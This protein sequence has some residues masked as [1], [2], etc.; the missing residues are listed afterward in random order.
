[1]Q[2]FLRTKVLDRELAVDLGHHRSAAH[3]PEE[4]GRRV[5]D[6]QVIEVAAL[7]RKVRRRRGKARPDRALDHR[8]RQGAARLI[9][10]GGGRQKAVHIYSIIA[11][12]LLG[13]CR[14]QFR[15]PTNQDLE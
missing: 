7:D 14:V 10:R 6:H 5:R 3:V 11:L 15:M 1:M 12:A 13:A 4:R 9:A 2:I 8:Q